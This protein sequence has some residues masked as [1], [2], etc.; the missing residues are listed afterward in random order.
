MS[1]ASYRENEKRRVTGQ[2]KPT[3]LPAALEQISPNHSYRP[4][5]YSYYHEWGDWFGTL[6]YSERMKGV[7]SPEYEDMINRLVRPLGGLSCDDI[8]FSSVTTPMGFKRAVKPLLKEG[9][10]VVTDIKYGGDPRYLVHAVGLLPTGEDGF[11][12][13]VSNHIPKCLAGIVTLQQVGE[14]VAV[15]EDPYRPK[16]PFNNANVWGLP[17]R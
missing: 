3:C 16:Y 17:P 10:R 9:Y 6:P 8:V 14:R 2:R 13:L 1:I 4:A 15:G 12:T 7:Y 11:V 5:I